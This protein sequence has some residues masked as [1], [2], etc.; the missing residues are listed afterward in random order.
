M[1]IVPFKIFVA[2]II[3]PKLGFFNSF[4]KKLLQFWAF[5]AFLPFGGAKKRWLILSNRKILLFFGKIAKIIAF[6]YIWV[7]NS[8][9]RIVDGVLPRRQRQFA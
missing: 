8:I 2:Y 3:L 9:R 7:Y 4:A 5:F 6:F 1:I